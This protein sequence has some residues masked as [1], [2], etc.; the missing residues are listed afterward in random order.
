MTELIKNIL[1]V[2]AG[3][4]ITY[5]L[6]IYAHEIILIFDFISTFKRIAVYNSLFEKIKTKIQ[7]SEIKKQF[8][9]TKNYFAKSLSAM[10]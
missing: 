2:G 8:S 4:F 1:I 5:R 3:S 6:R 7:S 10:I 9:K